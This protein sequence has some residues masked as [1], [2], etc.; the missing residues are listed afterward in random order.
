[1][2]NLLIVEPDDTQSEIYELALSDS[3]NISK[4]K[5]F[6]SATHALKTD[7]QHLVICEWQIEQQTADS[8][9]ALVD[10][11]D[12]FSE[13]IIIVVTEEKSEVAMTKAFQGGIS[14]YFTKP[15][16]VIQ[17]T[18]N[19]LALKKNIEAIHGVKKAVSE[20][21]EV[22]QTALS[23]A[24]IYG[25]GM[26]LAAS[27]SSAG[28]SRSIAKRILL[29]LAGS[30]IHCALSLRSENHTEYF[31]TDLT[32]CDETT[33]KVFNVLHDKGRIYRFGRRIMLNDG[34]V[35]LLVKHITDN[36]TV[37]YDCILDMG[38]KLITSINTQHVKLLQQKALYD[39]YSDMQVVLGKLNENV[40]NLSKEMRTIVDTVSA[41][42]HLS[43]H[44]LELTEVQENFFVD[45]IEKELESRANNEGMADLDTLLSAVTIRLKTKIDEFA[46]PAEQEEGNHHQ[47]I[48]FF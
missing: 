35:S 8:L 17:F 39:T 14:Y 16:K 4:V 34:D 24:S 37:I 42:I 28:D 3:F 12:Q 6:P 15:Y 20:S 21:Q 47:S 2:L 46:I 38:A 41:K 9:G 31:D 23:Q 33:E 27:I 26:D 22:T 29:T 10:E 19:I 7:H 40:I 1:M 44:E 45:L 36:D 48:E 25:I 5:D 13:P 32:P 11:G 43:F 30:G 18:E